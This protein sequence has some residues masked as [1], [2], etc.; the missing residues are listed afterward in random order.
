MTDRL[1]SQGGLRDELFPSANTI[2]IL[3]IQRACTYNQ[4]SKW[5]I[6]GLF[7]FIF[8]PRKHKQKNKQKYGKQ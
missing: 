4:F 5:T 8:G 2:F 7:L 1:P 3:N 6:F